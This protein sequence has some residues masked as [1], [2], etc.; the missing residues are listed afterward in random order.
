MSKT[1]IPFVQSPLSKSNGSRSFMG[2]WTKGFMVF[3]V[4]QKVRESIFIR[5]IDDSI[6][7]RIQPLNKY[8]KGVKSKCDY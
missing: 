3:K 6:F 8:S 5:I 4:V 1:L 7:V 2:D